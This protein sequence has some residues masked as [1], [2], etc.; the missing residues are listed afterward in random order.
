M[1][2][3]LRRT[4]Q[5][6]EMR[7][8]TCYMR[9]V[10]R[11]CAALGVALSLVLLLQVMMTVGTSAGQTKGEIDAPPQPPLGSAETMA[12]CIELTEAMLVGPPTGTVGISHTFTVT[13]GPVDA[14]LPV[15]YSWRTA[16]EILTPRFRD[17]LTDTAEF[18]WNVTGSQRVTVTAVNPCL[19]SV[20]DFYTITIETE[21]WDVYLPLALRNYRP[22][23]YE[24]NDTPAE[25]FGPLVSGSS[26][27]GYFPDLEDMYDYY[28]IDILTLE[29][30]DIHLTVPAQ[31][32]LDLFLYRG[33][34]YVKS[35]AE[36]GSGIDEA[37]E[38]TPE[39]IGT[40]Y[41][42]VHRAEGSHPAAAYTL[43]ATY[44][45]P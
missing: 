27:I 11:C 33:V 45:L 22:D 31:L 24:P 39:Q 23:P 13:V 42:L 37:I 41:I 14:D 9:T 12:S 28:Y 7:K 29:P 17:R 5:G 26:Y 10:L 1:L 35:S 2:A 30:I 19:E 43:V 25:A 38:F 15:T 4:Q 40:Y 36:Q 18:T 8:D 3:G 32:D 21:T 16:E 20:S 44:D 34:T 6:A